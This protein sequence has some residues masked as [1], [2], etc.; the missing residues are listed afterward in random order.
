MVKEIINEKKLSED[1]VSTR[2]KIIP[3][4]MEIEPP[5]LG[6]RESEPH[7]LGIMDIYSVLTTNFPSDRALMDLHHYF[8][9]NGQRIDIQFDVSYFKGMKLKYTLSSY[10]AA[11]FNNRIPDMAINILS[12]STYLKDLGYTMDMCESL[13]I[14][15]YV[16][17]SSHDFSISYYKPPFL[18][19]FILNEDG[20]YKRITIK[21]QL[22]GENGEIIK[23]NIIDTS[24]KVPF[25]I[26]I[27]RLPLVHEG[28]TNVYKL[29]FL[30]PNTLEIYKTPSELALEQIERE[31]ERAEREKERA[32]REKERAER[33]KER[34]ER[35]K[36]RAE[37]EKER[38]EREKERAEREKERANKLEK[39]LDEYKKKY[40]H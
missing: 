36:E 8:Y 32:E 16:L 30:N 20:I 2:H 39:I 37:R 26:S 6:R 7:S 21:G 38:A 12:K 4:E 31:K 9:I 13:K 17:F 11:K 14:P 28:G 15:I 19:V 22:L 29:V 24:S 10:D 25:N 40:E 33:E 23:A 34:A 5:R 18:R 1:F 35:E 27:M 3:E